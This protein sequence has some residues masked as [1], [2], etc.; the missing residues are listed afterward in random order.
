MRPVP[1]LL[2]LVS[3]VPANAAAQAVFVVRHAERADASRDS[4]LSPAGVARAAALDSA[5]QGAGLVKVVVTEFQR[6]QKTAQPLADR[7]GLPLQVVG[8]QGGDVAAHAR[9]VAEAVQARWIGADGAA[10]VVGHSN[11]VPAIVAALG[12]PRLPDLCDDEYATIV[13]VRQRAGGPPAV[14]RLRYGADDG[15]RAGGC[16]EGMMRPR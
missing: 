14:A 3:A 16:R 10:L 4:D 1:L 2:A 5:L 13:V 12:G 7:L 15:A 8:A 6:T 11:T 9:A